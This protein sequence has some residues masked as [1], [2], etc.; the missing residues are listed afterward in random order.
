MRALH[1]YLRIY[2]NAGYVYL[3]SY[4]HLYL[5]N[6]FARQPFTSLI[7]TLRRRGLLPL[8]LVLHLVISTKSRLQRYT[9]TSTRRSDFFHHQ[10]QYQTH[11]RC[12]RPKKEYTNITAKIIINTNK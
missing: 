11:R 12:Y 2:I 7:F 8:E 5:S 10:N 1:L 4:L 6:Y 3:S 9:S